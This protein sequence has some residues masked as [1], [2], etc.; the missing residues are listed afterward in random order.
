MQKFTPTAIGFATSTS[1]TREMTQST[2]GCK[3][4]FWSSKTMILNTLNIAYVNFETVL[5]SI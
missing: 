4:L 3:H 5:L 1:T 2:T